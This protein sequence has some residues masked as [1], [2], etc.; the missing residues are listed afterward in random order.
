MHTIKGKEIKIVQSAGL[1]ITDFPG[2]KIKEGSTGIWLGVLPDGSSR[3]AFVT[4][5]IEHPN[6]FITTTKSN[7][8]NFTGKDLEIELPYLSDFITKTEA[9]TSEAQRS[10]KV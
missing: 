4:T 7:I 5:N 8:F 6:M 9:E 1:D 3:L 2:I 10:I